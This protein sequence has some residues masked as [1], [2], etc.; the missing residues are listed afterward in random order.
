MPYAQ[1]S[2]V[3]SQIRLRKVILLKIVEELLQARMKASAVMMIILANANVMTDATMIV[4]TTTAVMM[5]AVMTIAV[6]MIL[7][8]MLADQEEEDKA[9]YKSPCIARVF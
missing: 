1:L 3:F 2:Q 9:H 5:T 7:V 6:T 8:M 4:A